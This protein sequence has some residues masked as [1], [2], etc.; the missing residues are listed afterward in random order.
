MVGKQADTL[1]SRGIKRSLNGRILRNTTL[2][3]LILV[4]ICCGIM[5]FSLQSLANSI[6][7][8]SLQPM[9]R[10]SAKTVEANIH[11]LADRMMTLA[12]DHGIE[13]VFTA[14]PDGRSPVPTPP[15]PGQT[16]AMF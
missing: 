4:V 13:T 14:G 3:I 1:A 9:A 15:Q 8:D 5:A 12:N 16:E 7:L 11:M 6:L 10:Q 2:N